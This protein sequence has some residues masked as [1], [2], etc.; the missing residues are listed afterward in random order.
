MTKEEKINKILCMIFNPLIIPTY[1]LIAMVFLIPYFRLLFIVSKTIVILY[2][3]SFFFMTFLLPF[4]TIYLMYRKKLIDNLYIEDKEQRYYPL[5]VTLVY[6]LIYLLFFLM[7]INNPILTI[8]VLVF[9]IAICLAILLTYFTKISFYSISI[10]TIIGFIFILP[11]MR[12]IYAIIVVLLIAGIICS[13][14]L[15]LNRHNITQIVLG[16]IVGFISSFLGLL[17]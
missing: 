7:K 16:L 17:F 3:L 4:I 6:Y 14:R 1:G 12:N 2:C 13:S 5:I 10:G 9:V 8:L 11:T 15:V